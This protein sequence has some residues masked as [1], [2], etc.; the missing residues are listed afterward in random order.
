MCRVQ[1]DDPDVEL[2]T[3]GVSAVSFCRIVKCILLRTLKK[4]PLGKRGFRLLAE[5]SN[6]E[7][8]G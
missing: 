3:L 2:C 5:D 1:K 4:K 8:S 6:L 7:P